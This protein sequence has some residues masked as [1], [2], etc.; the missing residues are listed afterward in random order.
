M[1]IIYDRSKKKPMYAVLKAV[2]MRNDNGF[3]YYQISH[4]LHASV[5]VEM[6][7]ER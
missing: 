1:T 6:N 2:V 3:F 5:L 7:S 4:G